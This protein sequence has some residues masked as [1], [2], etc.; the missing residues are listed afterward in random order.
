MTTRQISKLETS[1]LKSMIHEYESW[2][3]DPV[4]VERMRSELERRQEDELYDCGIEEI[5]WMV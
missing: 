3:T 2:G 5:G 4:V 1:E